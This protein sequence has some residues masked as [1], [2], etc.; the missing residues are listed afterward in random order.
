MRIS[1][2]QLQPLSTGLINVMQEDGA[3][4]E[5]LLELLVGGGLA[6]DL[7]LAGDLGLALLP[8]L[9]LGS[10]GGAMFRSEWR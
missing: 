4:L 3:N 8:V 2:S 10:G 7:Q 9:D 1:A 6:R 5:H